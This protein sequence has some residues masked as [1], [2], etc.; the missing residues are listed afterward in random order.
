MPA[1][2]TGSH[3]SVGKQGLLAALREQAQALGLLTGDVDGSSDRVFCL[4]RDTDYQQASSRE[5]ENVLSKDSR[6][7]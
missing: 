6:T 2:S 1:D 7:G 4:V 3:H 5:P